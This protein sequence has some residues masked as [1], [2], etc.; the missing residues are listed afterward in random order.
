MIAK[1]P[2]IAERIAAGLAAT[3]YMQMDLYYF[4]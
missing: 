2:R 1:L 4:I 3:K